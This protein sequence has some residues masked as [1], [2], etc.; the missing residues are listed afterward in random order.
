MRLGLET[1]YPKRLRLHCSAHEGQLY[2]W[3]QGAG[4][5]LLEALKRL[6]LE[7]RPRS[8]ELKSAVLWLPDK[9]GLGLEAWERKVL[10]CTWSYWWYLYENARFQRT[11]SA[12]EFLGGD[13]R[14]WL[15]VTQFADRLLAEGSYLPHIVAEPKGFRAT[16]KPVLTGENREIQHELARSMPDSARALNFSRQAPPDTPRAE[17]LLAVLGELIDAGVRETILEPQRWS[18]A[19]SYARWLTALTGSFGAV[20]GEASVLGRLERD[21][22]YWRAGLDGEQSAGRR[23]EVELAEPQGSDEPDWTVSLRW[24]GDDS[25]CAFADVPPE[26]LGLAWRLAEEA[27]RVYPLLLRLGQA[28]WTGRLRLRAEE[29]VEFFEHWSDELE[30]AGFLVTRPLG[31]SPDERLPIHLQGKIRSGLA[32]AD[33]RLSLDVLVELD[34]SVSV[35][36]NLLGLEEVEAMAARNT[37]LHKVNGKWML[38]DRE[39]LDAAARFLARQRDKQMR[40]R[41]ALRMALGLIPVDASVEIDGVEADG[42]VKSLLDQLTSGEHMRELTPPAGLRGE[43]RPYQVRGYSWMSFLSKFGL[44]A[45][46]ADDMGLGKSIQTLAVFLERKALQKA[47]A[48]L[49][50]PT[51]VIGNWQ[52]EAQRFAPELRVLI[53]HGA[54]RRKKEDFAG[55]VGQYDVVLASYALAHRD[56]ETLKQI[57]WDGIVLDEAQNIKNA[58]AKQTL[59]IRRL[60]GGYKLALTGTPVENNVGDLFSIMQFL[61]PGHLGSAAEF[62]R[63]FFVPIQKRGE[64]RA[65]RLLKRLTAPFLLRRLKSDRSI[66]A[67]LPDKLEMKV[68]C[69]LT[70]EQARLYDDV[71]RA[72]FQEINKL[73]GMAR[74]GSILAT[75]SKLKQVCNHPLQLLRDGGP[76]AER[77]GKLLRLEEMLEEI[78]EN[79]EKALVFSQFAEMGEILQ[80]R[81]A[82]KFGE[83]VFFLYGGTKREERDRMVEEFHAENGPGIFVLS[84]KAGGTGLNLT[85]ATH[86]FHY[87]RW[88]NP[89]VENQATD[90]AY[91]IGQTHQVEVHKFLTM[92]TV[93]ERIDLMLEQKKQLAEQVVDG[94]ET[95]LTEMSNDELRELFTLTEDALAD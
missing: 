91:R 95:W 44:G 53:H 79:K 10:A 38:V 86:V 73:S 11:A 55:Q 81:L 14:Y 30:A 45:C 33:A 87:D 2:F 25:G 13:F 57:E 64:E 67:D 76:V 17:I 23:I 29:V 18:G 42:W 75:L 85:A 51:S 83:K 24:T 74:R 37:P 60:R 43:L 21:L 92:G 48:L 50:C 39:G 19:G 61:N 89:A 80:A 15:A 26:D 94:A 54:A 8:Q 31:F 82:E 90:R 88:W 93:E 56:E 7:R 78:R 3:A 41:D 5:G 46:L 20:Q 27:A 28:Q 72:Q 84:L 35:D 12:N 70:K 6:G 59:A 71:V 1:F 68:F 47:P 65:S 9:V 52:R 16:W 69:K 34:W 22:S 58:N 40:L 4:P 36:Q 63:R 32:P 77:S 62:Q 49:I 66:I